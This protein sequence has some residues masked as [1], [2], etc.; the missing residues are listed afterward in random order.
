RVWLDEREVPPGARWQDEIEKVIQTVHS[1]VVLVGR[2]GFGPWQALEMRAYLS[3]MVKRRLRVIPVLLPGSPAMP[4]LPVFLAYNTWLDLRGGITE[5][6]LDRLQWGITGKK[7]PPRQF[8]T[9][10]FG[11][12]LHNLPFSSLGDLFTGREEELRMLQDGAATAIT[13]AETISGL[14]GV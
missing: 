2:D 11:P 6:G 13:Q 5:E 9:G 10:S 12:R 8:T 1:A 3:E 4:D 7:P 14:G